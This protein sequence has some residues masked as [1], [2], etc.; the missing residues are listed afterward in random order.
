M[1]YGLSIISAGGYT[2]VD[3][4][5]GN[6]RIVQEGVANTGSIV[7]IGSTNASPSNPPLIFV[8]PPYN[9][10]VWLERFNMVD[11]TFRLADQGVNGDVYQYKYLVLLPVNSVGSDSY[12]L[13]VFGESGQALF[14]SNY[15]YF[16]IDM[17]WRYN[18]FADRNKN[19]PMPAVPNGK[20]RYFLANP[21]TF[22]F[23]SGDSY[24]TY[25][26]YEGYGSA[27]LTSETNYLTG[28]RETTSG[29]YDI[30][31]LGEGRI[32]MTGTYPI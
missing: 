24:Q 28:M 27:G 12:G 6:F 16:A 20:E 18:P 14:D 13:R 32:F 21:L 23:A 1:T 26:T 29:G 9:R 11:K 5:F 4:A 31:Y 7:S 8:R 3:D 10:R 2:Q 19:Y 25:I 17:M 15:P 22:C 30:N